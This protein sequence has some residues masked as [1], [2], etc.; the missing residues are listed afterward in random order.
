M[1]TGTGGEHI[2]AS[3]DNGP[4]LQRGRA[5]ADAEG[6]ED[7]LVP[8]SDPPLYWAL[9]DE[10][11]IQIP[12]AERERTY[13]VVDV[14][15]AARSHGFAGTARDL[16]RVII[17]GAP[18]M[19]MRLPDNATMVLNAADTGV[20]ERFCL[21]HG[22]SIRFAAV[23]V[24][25]HQGDV[26][27]TSGYWTTYSPCV[28]AMF[29]G[30]PLP[31]D[32]EDRV[33]PDLQERTVLRLMQTARRHYRTERRRTAAPRDDLTAILR[34]L[35]AISAP[36]SIHDV[37]YTFVEQIADTIDVDRC[38]VVRI[39]NN[40]DEGM[41]LASHEDERLQNR[42][43]DLAKYPEIR[44]ALK[45]GETAVINDVRVS[46]IMRPVRDAMTKAG[47]IAVLVSPITLFDNNMGSLLLR[48][49]RRHE[50]FIERDVNFCEIVA[51]SAANALERA[52]LIDSIQG[53]NERLERLAVTDGLTGLYNFRFFRDRLEK[54][55]SRSD[56]YGNPLSCILID[57]DDFKKVNDTYG[58]LQGD[59]I[60][61]DIAG[62]AVKSNRQS[63]V[64]ARYGGEELVALLP[65]TGINGALRQAERLRDAIESH[66]FDGLSQGQRVTVSIG[67]AEFSKDTMKACEDLV[68]AADEGLYAAKQRGKNQV[69]ALQKEQV[70]K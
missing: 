43:I 67:V 23:V 5:F 31:M 57:I 63:D 7:V 68:R 45:T 39:K 15:T 2:V 3:A 6:V 13:A 27:E 33:R 21:L 40:A 25:G 38:S 18:D 4:L 49:A 48:V 20:P 16:N 24:E 70:P 1:G 47:F 64:V 8:L 50:G 61:R 66:N 17:L 35:Q 53:A 42:A 65:Q 52:H 9:V 56:R 36:G 55:F 60:L 14:H 51:E 30:F 22:P 58:H 69:V 11:F 37:L 32:A 19:D 46:D 29:R 59:E 54:E 41:V 12:V 10:A 28:E 34:V 26:V 62:I 44:R